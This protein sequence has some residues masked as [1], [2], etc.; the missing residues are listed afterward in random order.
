MVQIQMQ[1]SGFEAK[2]GARLKENSVR[3]RRQKTNGQYTVTIPQ[4]VAKSLALEGG[5][6]LQVFID[7]GD[8]VLRVRE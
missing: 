7:K 6:V 8:I 3:L 5:E 1:K 4:G 2:R